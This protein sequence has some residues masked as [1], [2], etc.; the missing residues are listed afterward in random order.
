MISG[1]DG[2]QGHV[3]TLW[4]LLKRY[5]IPVF[6]WINKMDQPGTDRQKLQR[7]LKNRLDERCLYF[8]KDQDS[9]VFLENLA[10]CD[11]ELLENYL[12]T[13]GI[14]TED[15]RSLIRNRKVFPCYYG[16]AL[17]MEG[18]EEF[19]EGLAHYSCCPQ[20]PEGFGARIYKIARDQQGNRLTYM[21][22]TGGSLKVKALLT[23]RHDACLLYTSRCV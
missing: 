5:Q 13:G 17:R 3:I 9:D 19:L 7:E 4:R 21:K 18:V 16:S 2:V 14:G 10:M 20:Y 12:E 15:I 1:T 11:E 8:G 22:I 6:F 23:N